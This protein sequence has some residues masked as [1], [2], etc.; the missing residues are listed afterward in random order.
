MRTGFFAI[1]ATTG[2]ISL[3]DTAVLDF[4]H[5]AL[6]QITVK[7]T[8]ASGA[9]VTQTMAIGV[10]DI[11]EKPVITSESVVSVA[12]NTSGTVYS[13]RAVDPDN[14][15]SLTYSLSGSDAARFNI[16]ATSG[17][18][19]F[20]ASPDYEGPV[21]KGRNNTYDIV[22]NA[23]D[24][25]NTSTQAVAITV[26]NVSD[27]SIVSTGTPN[28]DFTTGSS[29]DDTL[30]G[31][32]GNDSLI[33]GAG[34]DVLNG[35]ADDDRLSGDAGSDLFIMHAGGGSDIVAGGAG[36]NWTDMLELRTANGS[37]YS[38][39]LPTDWTLILT[40][41]SIVSKNSESLDLSSDSAGT[42]QHTDGTTVTFTE[43]EHI[44]W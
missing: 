16:D 38:G 32:A 21:D 11:N 5:Q 24:G 6:Y 23:S 4:E 18:V 39:E 34:N 36:T 35:G 33:G 42:L 30:N 14:G 2:Q 17:A 31:G 1:D 41:G 40:S 3:T 13:A 37:T 43:I 27:T 20:N 25:T 19:S 29:A 12:E 26:T 15:A 7:V 44:R 8:D 10:T 9:S 22:V 28:D